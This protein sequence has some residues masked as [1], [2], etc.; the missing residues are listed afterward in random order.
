M[1]EIYVKVY[2]LFRT[3][4]VFLDARV[5]PVKPNVDHIHNQN[6]NNCKMIT[7]KHQKPAGNLHFFVTESFY[8]ASIYP[9]VALRVLTD[10]VIL[11]NNSSF[12]ARYQRLPADQTTYN[13]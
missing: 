9:K 1:F 8:S 11:A 3:D 10:H 2:V 12:V 5:V 7:F 6:I 13:H 4:V